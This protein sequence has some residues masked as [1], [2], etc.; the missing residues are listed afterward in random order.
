MAI[1]TKFNFKGIDIVDIYIRINNIYTVKEKIMNE[2]GNEI[3]KYI[4]RYEFDVMSPNKDNVIDK[5]SI[6]VEF[7]PNSPFNPYELGYV[8]LKKLPQ[9]KNSLD[10]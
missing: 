4:N 6:C 3:V 9:Y 2:D 7:D 1:R 5:E 10:V 8:A